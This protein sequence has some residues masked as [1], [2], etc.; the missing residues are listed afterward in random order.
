M[1]TDMSRPRRL[2]FAVRL[3]GRDSHTLNVTPGPRSSRRRVLLRLVSLPVL[4]LFCLGQTSCA[5]LDRAR[6]L[7]DVAVEVSQQVLLQTVVE[8]NV[9]R[10]RLRRLRC[11]D[12]VLTPATI[13]NAAMDPRLGQ[14]WVDE[15]LRDCPAFSAFLM[16]SA[17]SRLSPAV[18]AARTP[19]IQGRE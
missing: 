3:D 12:P 16:D 10:Q 7:S 5:Y 17:M 4:T 18:L 8:A 19:E 14:P 11:V 13:S 15:L 6:R 9:E 1:F 2:T